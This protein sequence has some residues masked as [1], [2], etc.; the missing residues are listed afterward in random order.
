MVSTEPPDLGLISGHLKAVLADSGAQPIV[1][2][3]E[4]MV[5][6]WVAPLNLMSVRVAVAK[7]GRLA[8]ADRTATI[9]AQAPPL[10]LPT[11]LGGW[12][13]DYL[14]RM[15]VIL[16]ALNYLPTD[17]QVP[18]METL[19]RTGSER[20]QASVLRCLAL[21]PQ[22]GRFVDLASEATRTNAVSVF[23]ALA[24]E[25]E[26]PAGYLPE[27]NFNQLV[28]KA[29]FLDLDSSRIV[30]LAERVT[31][32]LVRMLRDYES[33]RRAAS[34]SVPQDIERISALLPQALRK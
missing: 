8:G 9:Q 20:E 22:A 34:R 28:L 15:A 1:D 19:Y 29:L 17:D 2:S 10:P 24:C 21:L 31:P 6:G 27:L 18:L 12:P 32:E 16:A 26:Y 5:S 11:P 14:A 33:E 30:G 7:L 25:N 3:L 23:R 13:L 4:A